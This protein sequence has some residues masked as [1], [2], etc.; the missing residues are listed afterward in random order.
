MKLQLVLS[1][2]PQS[3]LHC[4]VQ[5]PPK[6]TLS[7]QKQL[8]ANTFLISRPCGCIER[9]TQPGTPKLTVVFTQN[10][11]FASVIPASVTSG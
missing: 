8:R 7:T 6:E 10:H 5:Q 2:A 9:H 1:D 3:M 4:P 11:I